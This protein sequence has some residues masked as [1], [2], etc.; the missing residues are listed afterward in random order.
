MR[1]LLNHS[2]LRAFFLGLTVLSG[3]NVAGANAEERD[4][5]L[6]SLATFSAYTPSAVVA[7]AQFGAPGTVLNSRDPALPSIALV[8]MPVFLDVSWNVATVS[9]VD[10]PKTK[11]PA[12][13]ASAAPPPSGSRLPE[14]SPWAA[15]LATLMLIGFFL[16]RRVQ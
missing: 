16:F 11:A 3:L 8:D 7:V 14:S 2:W 13:V 1:S 5:R 15:I 9:A 4:L 6:Q 12:R 10:S